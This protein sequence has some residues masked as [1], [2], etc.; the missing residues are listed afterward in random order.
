MLEELKDSDLFKQAMGVEDDTDEKAKQAE[1][2]A[3]ELEAKNK[4]A[5]QAAADAEKE[6]AAAEAAKLAET[7]TKEVK[8]E[9]P[10]ADEKKQEVVTQTYDEWFTENEA[11]LKQYLVEK[12]RDYKSMKPEDLIRIKYERENP[13]LSKEE[14][15]GLLADDYSLG[16]KKI[17]INTDV[18]D[19]EEIRAADAHNKQIEKSLRKLNADA[20]KAAKEFDSQKASLEKPVYKAPELQADPTE[21]Y[22][23][24]EFQALAEEDAKLAQEEAEKSHTTWV[25]TVDENVKLTD[26]FT[27]QGL[28]VDL[29]KEDKESIKKAIV[30]YIPKDGDVEAY[31]DGKGNIVWDKFTQDLAKTVLLDKLIEAAK[32]SAKTEALKKASNYQTKVKNEAAPSGDKSEVEEIEDIFAKMAGN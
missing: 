15:D 32:G 7:K 4:A 12:D 3:A 1:T 2:E 6:T 19:D 24:E 29:T 23:V 8:K 25:K 9:A 22:T 5:E 21:K 18:M 28:D 11:K 16:E 20:K 30:T 26:S 17:E 27:Y 14:V 31:T 10:K 13:D